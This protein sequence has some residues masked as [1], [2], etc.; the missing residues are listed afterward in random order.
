MLEKYGP[1]RWW[2]GWAAKDRATISLFDDVRSVIDARR[3]TVRFAV[4]YD[5][6][7]AL[8]KGAERTMHS[9]FIGTRVRKKVVGHGWYEGRVVCERDDGV[10]VEWGGDDDDEDEASGTWC[11]W[12]SKA[13]LE[14]IRVGDVVV[15]DTVGMAVAKLREQEQAL[16]GPSEDIQRAEGWNE[17]RN[18]KHNTTP[19]AELEW[20]WACE[21]AK[22]AYRRALDREINVLKL[23]N[24]CTYVQATGKT[25]T[26]KT[27]T[28]KTATGKTATG[29]TATGKTAT[30]K[31]VAKRSQQRRQADESTAS[32]PPR[33]QLRAGDKVAIY[34]V[35]MS[36]WERGAGGDGL[37]VTKIDGDSV[38]VEQTEM[39]LTPA[40]SVQKMARILPDGE[41]HATRSRAKLLK[42]RHRTAPRPSLRAL[43]ARA[44]NSFAAEAQH[45]ALVDGEYTGSTR[46]A[47]AARQLHSAMQ[48]AALSQACRVARI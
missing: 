32:P 27:A 31:N 40:T 20:A 14:K 46:Q 44:R 48:K 36:R 24:I 9:S 30:G 37:I 8:E 7:A 12:V 33:E 3:P 2:P 16:L 26:G 23:T 22:L 13:E 41:Y 4:A 34:C 1:I 25:A 29:K 19:D 11:Q 6:W 45:F 21:Q 39:L 5:K 35:V 15:V 10:E 17:D 28:G 38:T 47:E 42:V 43:R 18:S